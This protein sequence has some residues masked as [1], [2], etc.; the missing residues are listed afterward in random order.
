MEGWP[1][2]VCCGNLIGFDRPKWCTDCGTE[3]SAAVLAVHRTTL[4]LFSENGEPAAVMADPD[5]F[6][7]H[8]IETWRLRVAHNV[9]SEQSHA[10]MLMDRLAECLDENK[11]PRR[12][13]MPTPILFGTVD[14]NSIAEPFQHQF[15]VSRGHPNTDTG[16]I[17][18]YDPPGPL[19]E[20]DPVTVS[21]WIPSI[22]PDGQRQW[23]EGQASYETG[24]SKT[25]DVLLERGHC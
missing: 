20:G 18:N 22:T 7:E 13:P 14:T 11:M 4:N 12:E 3:H 2:D 9:A 1:E 24:W 6:R 19:R 25:L 17:E 5:K 16:D 21:A 8:A 15:V 23:T 10:S